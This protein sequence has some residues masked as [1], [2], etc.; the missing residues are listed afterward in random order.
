MQTFGIHHHS[1]EFTPEGISCLQDV[2]Y[3]IETYDVTT[4]RAS[5]PKY[6]LGRAMV[7]MNQNGVVR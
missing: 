4:I 6:L 1:V 7:S 2:I 3:A 5:V